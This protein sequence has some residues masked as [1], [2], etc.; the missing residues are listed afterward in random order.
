MISVNIQPVHMAILEGEQEI[1]LTEKTFLDEYFNDIPLH[2]RPK[3]FFKPIPML[4]R[5]CMQRQGI[6]SKS[7][8]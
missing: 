1:V 3:G 8:R 4:P 7:C 6:G 5:H 2:V